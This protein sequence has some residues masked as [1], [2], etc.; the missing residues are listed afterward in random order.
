MDMDN[1]VEMDIKPD[2]GD[3]KPD[4]SELQPIP[5]GDAPRAGDGDSSKESSRKRDRSRDRDKPRRRSRSRDRDRDRSRR[6][7]GD[8]DAD[9]GLTGRET[10]GMLL[11]FARFYLLSFVDI[12][13]LNCVL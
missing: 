10:G 13:E 4:V 12:I 2:I 5:E 7:R 9:F 3:I 8:R 1:G 11:F 6:D